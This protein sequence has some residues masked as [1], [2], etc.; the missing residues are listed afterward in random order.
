LV[1][2]WQRYWPRT[3]HNKVPGGTRGFYVLYRKGRG[4]RY[5]VRY[6][7]AAG[8]RK[9]GGIRS[10][11]T[12]HSRKKP[13]WTHFSFFEVHDNITPEEIRELEALLLQIFRHDPRIG[14]TNV[15]RGSRKFYQVRKREQWK[16]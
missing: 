8:L 9:A 3:D 6:I 13:G 1:K 11:V 15:Q 12:S 4:E 16:V 7:G 2:R 10:R 14:L 5:E